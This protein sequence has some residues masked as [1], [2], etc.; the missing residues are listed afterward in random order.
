MNQQIVNN[1]DNSPK[2]LS[3]ELNYDLRD[4]NS[5]NMHLEV[6]QNQVQ[7]ADDYMNIK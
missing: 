3:P 4:I 1:F 6:P 2:D 5:N 7:F